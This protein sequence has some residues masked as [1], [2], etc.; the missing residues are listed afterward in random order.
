M[1]NA[2]VVI[3]TCSI[4]SLSSAQRPSV[5]VD[6]IDAVW[7]VFSGGDGVQHVQTAA[8]S[9]CE[10]RGLTS[11]RF[12]AMPYYP[13]D[14]VGYLNTPESYWTTMDC[15]IHALIDGGCNKLIP[16]FFFNAFTVS[17]TVKEPLGMLST[18][19]RAGGASTA[20]WNTSNQYLVDFIT[21]YGDSPA[22][23]AWEIGNEW[24]L[25][26]D[27]DQSTLCVACNPPGGTPSFRTRA[28][29]ISTSDWMVISAGWASTIRAADPLHRPIT[30]GHAVARPAAEH[31]RASYYAAERDWSEWCPE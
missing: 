13:V 3:S 14:F 23:A 7:S 8:Q 31:L 15:A 21:R 26:C 24:N 2:H 22:I 10:Q 12:A 9:A 16:S 20:S 19:A 5:G 18:G 4:L 6:I 29:N 17:D 25:L 1:L 28:D 27:I 30:S 11:V